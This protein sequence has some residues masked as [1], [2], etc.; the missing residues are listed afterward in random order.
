MSKIIHKSINRFKRIGK[1]D[2]HIHSNYSDGAPS[3]EEI[4]E[5]VQE[6]T[7]LDVIAICDHN[8]IEGALLASH[9]QKS[10]NYRF[11]VIVGEEI[12][13]IE[14]HIVA[15]FLKEAI[16][17]DISMKK[18]LCA[19]KK[20]GGL[21]I[22]A[23]PFYH[24]KL[25]NG[26]MEVMNGVGADNLYK[27]HHMLDAIE[28]VNATPALADENLAASAM[29]RA[30]LYLSETGSSDAHILDAIGRAYTAFEGKTAADLKKALKHSQTQAIFAGWTFLAL[31]KYLY[32]FIPV[33]FRLLWFNTFRFHQASQ[34]SQDS[35]RAG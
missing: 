10:G 32:F 25:L 22:A 2:I 8:S 24:T 21:A 23:H 3:I 28:I 34:R 4:M 9:M 18:A 33:G 5:Y 6:N 14:G 20:Q 15:L 12:S 19:I 31:L 7:D 30:V 29:N 1:A 13:C 27:Y 26:E 11:E 17:G 16:P 35:C